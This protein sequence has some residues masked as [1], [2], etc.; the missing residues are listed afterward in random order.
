MCTTTVFLF[1]YLV[2]KGV[3]SADWSVTFKNQCAFKG[4]SV[5]IKC[6]YDYPFGHVV[7]SVGW[8]KGQ[9]VLGRWSLVP[10][11][12]SPSPPDHIRY[13]GN[14][15]GDCSLEIKDLEHSDEGYYSF[16][17]ATTFGRWT[18]RTTAH[19]SVKGNDK[20]MEA[21]SSLN[22]HVLVEGIF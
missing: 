15:R 4:T 6:K 8:A 21:K 2:P 18:S 13:V 22:K 10:L 14:Y 17:F 3:W 20:I 16:S 5:V 9:Q 12:N 11:S 19:L 7:T 1:I